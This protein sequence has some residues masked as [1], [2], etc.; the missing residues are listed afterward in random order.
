MPHARRRGISSGKPREVGVFRAPSLSS[1]LATSL[2]V[3]LA[4]LISGTAKAQGNRGTR[5]SRTVLQ[6]H[7]NPRTIRLAVVNQ[8]DIRFTRLSTFAG[9]SQMRVSTIVQD[10]KGFIWFGTQYGLNRYDGYMFKIFLH[11]PA[12]PHS[13]SGVFINS[14]FK[15]RSGTLW[16]GCDQFLDR[17]DPTTET[18]VHYRLEAENTNSL[19]FAV[20]HISQDSAG[21]LWLATGNGLYSLDP[22]SGRIRNYSHDPKDPSS[23]SSNDVKSSSED[24]MGRFWVANGEGL[25]QFDRKAGK[26]TLHI[27][28]REPLREF[29]F[30]EDRLGVFWVLHVSGNGLAVFDAK[31][32]TLTHYSFYER[33]SPSTAVSGV[34]TILEDRNG[35][36]WLGTQGAGLLKFDREHQRFIAYRHDPFDPGSLAEDSVNSLF[37]DREGNIWAGLGAV[38]LNRFAS[39]P[40]PFK[41]LPHDLGRPNSKGETFINAIHGDHEGN[42]WISTREALH[43]IDRDAGQFTSYGIAD[44]ITIIEDGTGVLWIG[45]YNHGLHRLDKRTGQFKAYR[46]S[47]ADQYSLSNDIVARLLV[48]HNGTLWAATY[49]GLNRFDFATERFTTYKYDPKDKNL[50]YLEL[51]EGGQG[52]LWLGTHASGLQRFD[53]ATGQFTAYQHELSH[54]GTLSDS[55]VN[56]VHFDRAGVM[57]VGTQNGLN[58]FD[59]A[60]GT[61]TIYTDRDGLPGNAI[62]CVLEDGRGDLWMSTNNG[63]SRFNPLRKTFKNYS[64]AEGLPGPDLTGLGACFKS[65]GGE[66]FFGGF[67]GGIAFHPDR[68]EDSSYIPPVVLTDFRLSG[69]PVGIGDRSPLKRSISYASDLTLSHEQDV[70][71]I[72]FA[73]LSYA[74]P[75][76]NRYRYKLEGLERKWI[77]VG[78][79]LRLATYT[80]LPAGSYSFRVQGAT[81]SGAWSEPGVA[82]RIKILPPWWST[83]W[84]RSTCAALLVLIAFAAY[85]YRLR[86]IA[87]HFEL[88]LEERIGERTRI[89]RE[90]HDTLLQGFQ[91]LMFRLQAVRDLLPERPTEAFQVLDTALDRGD[92]AIAEGRNA[93]QGLRSSTVIDNDLVHGLTVLAEELATPKGNPASATFRLLVEGRPRDLDPILRDEIYRI[94]R[95]ALGNAFRHARAQKIEAE[96]T[97]GDRLFHLRIR[98]DGSGIDPSVRDRGSRA[99]HWG[100]TGMRERAKTLGGRLEVWSQEGAG[101]EVDL[102]IPTSLAYGQSSARSKYRLLRKKSEKRERQT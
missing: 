91:G 58:R 6:A 44:V 14:L 31:T 40:L 53:P 15:D 100:L 88:R 97:Y 13:L 67:S 57:W 93:V 59:P 42:L 68:V 24:R 27:P 60:T 43:R 20:M 51:V 77:E 87:R 65:P 8:N 45:T 80:T 50:F 11:E 49:D 46:H 99:G 101:T 86:Q 90:L 2:V 25:D 23:L 48:D 69:N 39:E 5:A 74:N 37:E 56:S 34:K 75:A 19:P 4:V 12:N 98:D 33:E 76:A 73:A 64:T 89:A 81:S 71:S 78:S 10:D 96:I 36:L 102:T 52:T 66:M 55:R 35:N 47:A 84:F 92:Q 7:V 83:W 1:A 21:I 54:P 3:S 63:I 41:N 62:G 38:G 26:V 18:F 28:L 22:A 61:F 16:I 79:D 9:L 29:S 85:S 94:A 70:F 72:T 30:Y 32:N 17:F 82:L 95:E